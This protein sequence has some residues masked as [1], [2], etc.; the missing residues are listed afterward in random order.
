M[1]NELSDAN[2]EEELPNA[3][4]EKSFR[5]IFI[6]KVRRVISLSYEVKDKTTTLPWYLY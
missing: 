2:G 5:T 6:E 4:S 1:L 3:E